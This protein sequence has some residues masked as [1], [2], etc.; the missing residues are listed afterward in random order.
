[1]TATPN[2]LDLRGGPLRPCAKF[3][4]TIAA[5]IGV[6]MLTTAGIWP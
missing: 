2:F 6:G 3:V 4:A 1:V 5:S